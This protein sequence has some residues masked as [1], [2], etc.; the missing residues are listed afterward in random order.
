MV[1]GYY[2]GLSRRLIRSKTIE[3]E[4]RR[5]REARFVEG[6]LQVVGAG[7]II[8][9]VERHSG[10]MVRTGGGKGGLLAVL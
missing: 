6:V 5:L 1:R 2:R 3:V 9:K 4:P 7:L 8:G 10:E